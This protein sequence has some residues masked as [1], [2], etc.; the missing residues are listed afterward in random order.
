MKE[1]N[2]MELNKSVIHWFPGH[3]K[4]AYVKIEE[5]LK[6]IDF[7]IIVLDARA[8]FS[9]ANDYLIKVFTQKPKLFLLNKEDLADPENT[10]FWLNYYSKEEVRSIAI[11]SKA[12]LKK[13]LES[14]LIYLTENKRQK[15]LRK[16]IKNA[17][18]KGMIVGIPNVGK[19]TI[20]NQLIGKKRVETAN[21]PGVT[22][23]VNWIKISKEYYL[24][25]TPGILTPRFENKNESI[26]LAL[27]GS[28]RQEI[29]PLDVLI[30]YGVEFLKAHYPNQLLR[31]LDEKVDLAYLDRI[32]GEDIIKIIAN[33]FMPRLKDG[34]L[35]I[36]QAKLKFLN[37]FRNGNI[38]R[39]C[40]DNKDDYA[41][42]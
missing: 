33:K 35:N 42:L 34:V 5:Y 27:L 19:S 11:N 22:R 37:D 6:M 23:S 31:Y 29:L 20:I 41:K 16:G 18:Y 26:K 17:I 1:K 38:A 30:N 15:N 25:D 9:S 32:K 39:I 10:K 21:K 4:K 28:I 14:Q 40:L 36:N 3:M 2:D 24:M 8:P 7:V 12:G 13:I